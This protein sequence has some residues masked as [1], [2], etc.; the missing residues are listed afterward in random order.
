MKGG[1]HVRVCIVR[2]YYHGSNALY[3]FPSMR[4]IEDQVFAPDSEHALKCLLGFYVTEDRAF[5]E[6]CGGYVYEIEL[7][8]ETECEFLDISEMMKDHGIACRMSFK[9]GCVYYIAKRRDY[10]ERGVSM[11]VIKEVDG[12]SGESIIVNLDAIRSFKR[13]R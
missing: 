4:V 2:K 9:D 10:V 12:Y 7:K 1:C 6:K 3:D 13:V 11:V 5:A 8:Y